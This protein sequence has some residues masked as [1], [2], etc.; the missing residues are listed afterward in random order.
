MT[1]P[2]STHCDKGYYCPSGSI[3]QIPCPK[4][5]FSSQYNAGSCLLCPSGSYANQTAST[6]CYP[7]PI[8]SYCDDPTGEPKKCP[9]GT[10][11]S[12]KSQEVCTSCEEGFYCPY[13]GMIAPII[14]PGNQKVGAKSCAN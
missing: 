6:Q 12:F 8:G 4:G 1:V 9:L 10:Y 11:A 2:D 13:E 5:T 7:C 14:C 3:A